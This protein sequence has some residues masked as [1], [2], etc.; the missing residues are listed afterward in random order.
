MRIFDYA[1]ALI[2]LAGRAEIILTGIENLSID[3]NPDF[4]AETET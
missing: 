3:K 2:H 4:I 1:S